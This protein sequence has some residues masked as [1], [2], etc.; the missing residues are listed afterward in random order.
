MPAA[1]SVL[2]K[3]WADQE[4]HGE[5]CDQQVAGHTDKNL[6]GTPKKGKLQGTGYGQASQRQVDVVYKRNKKGTQVGAKPATT[7]KLAGPS[8]APRQS[9]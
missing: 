9:P 5:H 4:A 8:E 2:G 6:G 3:R 7:T 1:D